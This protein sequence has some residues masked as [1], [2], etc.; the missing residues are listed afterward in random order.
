V[1]YPVVAEKSAR[2]DQQMLDALRKAVEGDEQLK[3][4]ASGAMALKS[5]DS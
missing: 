5:S 4:V 2:I 1:R 3:L